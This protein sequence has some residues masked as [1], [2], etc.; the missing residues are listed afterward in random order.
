MK[1][2]VPGAQWLEITHQLL[3]QIQRCAWGHHMEQ[4]IAIRRVKSRP[5]TADRATAWMLKICMDSRGQNKSYWNALRITNCKE[6]SN[7]R[8]STRGVNV[9]R[10]EEH[11]GILLCIYCT[12]S[13]YVYLLKVKRLNASLDE[14]LIWSASGV[15][16]VHL[17][18]LKELANPTWLNKYCVIDS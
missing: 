5:R 10:L 16:F 6:I 4:G 3:C 7:S 2:Q 17:W 15:F 18:T 1:S 11:S 12:L 9:W 13:I 8:K 14:A